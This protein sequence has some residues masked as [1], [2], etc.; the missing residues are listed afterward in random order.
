MR[1]REP[2]CMRKEVK[3]NEHLKRWVMTAIVA[4]SVIGGAAGGSV[5]SAANGN[6]ATGNAQ[7]TKLAPV[8]VRSNGTFKSNENASHEGNESAQCEAQETAG[9]MPTVP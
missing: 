9:Q 5:L 4:G 7:S 2:P 3:S 1:S 6:A 8:V